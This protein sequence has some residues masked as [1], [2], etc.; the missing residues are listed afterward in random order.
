ME[1]KKSGFISRL[2]EQ[3]SFTD[4]VL[5]EQA[6][7][8]ARLLQRSVGIAIIIVVLLS[9]ATMGLA[10]LVGHGQH[11]RHDC[12]GIVLCDSALSA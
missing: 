2:A 8:S 4:P 11:Y 3:A 6:T 10:H 1:N 9:W 12:Y 7:R 5:I